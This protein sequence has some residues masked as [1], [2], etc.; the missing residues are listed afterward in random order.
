LQDE[1]ADTI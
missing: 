1:V